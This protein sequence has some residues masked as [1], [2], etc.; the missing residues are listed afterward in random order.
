MT[1][2]KCLRRA[3]EGI[4]YLDLDSCKLSSVNEPNLGPLQKQEAFLTISPAHHCLSSTKPHHGD[5][6][7]ES[8]HGRCIWKCVETVLAKVTHCVTPVFRR[9]SREDKFQS[10]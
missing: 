6:K 5:M 1:T 10:L 9:Y 2:C 7:N 4:E 8:L 3:E